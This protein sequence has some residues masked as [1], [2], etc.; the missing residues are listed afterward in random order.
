MYE[1]HVTKICD[2]IQSV[3][4]DFELILFLQWT[5]DLLQFQKLVSFIT[6]LHFYV[7]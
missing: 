6:N 5:K 7:D 1:I 3:L 2:S 4:N